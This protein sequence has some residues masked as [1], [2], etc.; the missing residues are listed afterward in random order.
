[1][2]IAD[3][4]IHSKYSRATS[5]DCDLA[6]LDLWAR[7][8]GVGL[9]GTGDFTHPAWREEMQ[10]CLEE[11]GAGLYRLRK[12]LCLPLSLPGEE[13]VRFV[14]SGEI[15][16]IYKWDGKTRKVHHLI[17]LPSLQAAQELSRRLEI[18]GNIHSDGRPILGLDS[19]DL[20]Q[21]VFDACPEAVFIPAHIWTPHFSVFGAFSAFSSLEECYGPMAGRIHALETGLSSDPP[22]NRMLSSLDGYQLVSNSDAHSP[23]RIAREANL[24]AGTP[25]YAGLRRALET[26]DGLMGTIEFFPEEGKYHLDGHRACKC[27]LTPE[28]TAAAGGRCPVCG[29]KITVGVLNRVSLLADRREQ[30]AP[31]FKPFESLIPLPEVLADC[32][33]LSVASKKV[34]QAYEQALTRLGPE[35][36]ILRQTPLTRIREALGPLAEEAVSRLR[37]GKVLRE[38]GYDGEYGHISLFA[39]GERESLL[40]QQSFL[41]LAAPAAPRKKRLTAAPEQTSAQEIALPGENPGQQAAIAAEDRVT[42]VVAGPGTGKT[43][44]LVEHVAHMIDIQGIDPEE[45]TAV[46]FTAKAAEEMRL[47]LAARLGKEIAGKITVGT[48][49]AV[50]MGL[51]PKKT[52]ATRDLCLGVV[53]AAL[54]A[55]GQ[56]L[57]PAEALKRISARRNGVAG[58]DISDELIADYRARLEASGARDMDDLLEEA[59]A[60]DFSAL[61]GFRHVLVDEYQDVNLLQRKLV[62]RWLE[63]GASLFVI[64]DPDQSIYGFRGADADCFAQLPALWPETRFLRLE[65]NYRSTGS[66][67]SCAE[68]IIAQNPGQPRMLRPVQGPGAAVRLVS[69]PDAPSEA[70][71]I[72]SEI[73]RMVGGVDM[74]SAKNG[75]ARAFSDFAV[76]CRTRRQLD[77]MESAFSRQGIPC[78]ISGRD[79]SLDTPAARGCVAL[80]RALFAPKDGLSL[81]TALS[82]LWNVSEADSRPVRALV[83]EKGWNFSALEGLPG[84]NSYL[85]VFRAL[86]E[87]RRESPA[88]LLQAAF[89]LTGVSVPRLLDYAL[90]CKTMPGLL[91]L[92]DSDTDLTR[93]SG[94][95]ASGAVRLMTLHAAKGLEFPVVFLAGLGEG[96]LPL[97]GPEVN[98]R[99]ERRLLFVGV[100]RAREELI[101]TCPGAPSPFCQELPEDVHRETADAFRLKP[102]YQQLSFF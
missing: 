7:K 46:T 93:A 75:A 27:R 101:L 16:T 78:L 8:K 28:E 76:L 12:E 21:I 77:E 14:I 2:Y 82:L 73:A 86:W 30:D 6:H 19:R 34:Q 98:P 31:T 13:E 84:E 24:L 43:Y 97:S 47:R 60:L 50:C 11:D 67:L 96:L 71:W 87:K 40:G 5:R 69:A 89:A 74:N 57:S 72:A 37:A 32:M 58:V 66:I 64:G 85:P 29:K 51:L 4:H 20:I 68:K 54:R 80:F 49:H 100:T 9:L 62:R 91:S 102:Q 70:H 88:K 42:A 59:L 81:E 44:T 61:P 23:A 83:E 94:N 33:G 55:R 26:G 3:L 65:I 45:I 22:M 1:M 92:L 90:F 38:A 17:L 41:D 99:E 36:I 25:S 56:R 35:M 39:P 10:T 53:E 95:Y 79:D 48:F 18:I 52:L 15:S 63:S